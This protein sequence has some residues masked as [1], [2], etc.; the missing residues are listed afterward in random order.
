MKRIFH[1]I[2]FSPAELARCTEANELD[3][4]FKGEMILP[5]GCLDHAWMQRS[6][7]V[8]GT[9]LFSNQIS[10]CD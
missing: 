8:R 7:T 3:S 10:V 1:L 5:L 6:S 4:A 2:A 9:L